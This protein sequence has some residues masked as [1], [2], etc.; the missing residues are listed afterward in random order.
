MEEKKGFFGK[1][2]QNVEKAAGDAAKRAMEVAESSLPKVQ[3]IEEINV[4]EK[5]ELLETKQYPLD[6]RGGTESIE[7]TEQIS[8]TVSTDVTIGEE[9]LREAGVNIAGLKVIDAQ[10]KGSISRSTSQSVGESITRS[11]SLTFKAAPGS[12]V[13]YTVVW[14]QKVREGTYILDV[15]GKRT[16]APYRVIVDLSYQVSSETRS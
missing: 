6:N 1:L 12:F 10:I 4:V 13:V 11:Q 5:Q 16:E 14:T 2:R 15:N 8:K 3:V 7:S 9:R